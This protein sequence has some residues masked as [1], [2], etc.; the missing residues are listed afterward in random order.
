[1]KRDDSFS[2]RKLT[3]GAYAITAYGVRDNSQKAVKPQLDRVLQR[4]LRDFEKE[5]A[6]RQP[7]GDKE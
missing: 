4:T 5:Q 7:L 3:K 1:M 6:T 2:I